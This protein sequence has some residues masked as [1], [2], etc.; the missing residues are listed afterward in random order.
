[1]DIFSYNAHVLGISLPK[2]VVSE[3]PVTKNFLL[4][5]VE[6]MFKHRTLYSLNQY[7]TLG[8]AVFLRSEIDDPY[9]ILKYTT[10]KGT[11]DYYLLA[12]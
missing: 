12:F 4:K 1:M 3:D 9:F 11:L 2:L 6:P 8:R 7:K 10:M 5:V